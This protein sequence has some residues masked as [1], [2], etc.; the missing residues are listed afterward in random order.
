MAARVRVACVD[1]LREARRCAIAR[2]AVGAFRELLQL[3]ELDVRR[4]VRARTVLAV[5]LRPVERAVREADQLVAPDA[6]HRIRRDA[7]ADRQLADLLELRGTDALDDRA[8]DRDAVVRVETGEEHRELV[9]AEPEALAALAQPRRDLAEHAVADRVAVAV[10]DVLEVVDVH[11]AERERGAVLLGLRE[12]ALQPLVEVAVVAETRERIGEREAHRLQRRE[13]RALIERDREQRADERHRE[14]RRALPEHDEHERRGRHQRERRRRLL[15]VVP[16]QLEER[17][18]RARREH[19]A[20]QHEV[21]D[22]VVEERADRDPDDQEADRVLG[23]L[24]DHEPAGERRQREHRAVVGDPKR[25]AMADQMRDGRPAGRD[26]HAGLPPEEDDR[27]DRE[28]EAERD[29]AGVDALYGH[30]ETLGE[31]H[32]EEESC[33]R[34]AVSGRM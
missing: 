30:R 9:A 15:R 1:R 29:A 14:R 6:L 18:A 28:D 7:G 25:R 22:P 10:V 34:Q 19:G 23:D 16:D 33:D 20:D 2:R 8:R 21:D 3:L 13:R 12:L 26:D 32:A 24:L 4:L 31:N 17:L 27:G 5:F 11:E